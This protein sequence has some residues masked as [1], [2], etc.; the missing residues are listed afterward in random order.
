MPDGLRG[1]YPSAEVTSAFDNV[2][3]PNLPLNNVTIGADNNVTLSIY[4]SEPAAPEA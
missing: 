1:T 4:M 2:T 3:D